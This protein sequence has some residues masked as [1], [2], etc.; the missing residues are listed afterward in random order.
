MH[1]VIHKNITLVARILLGIAYSFD[2]ISNLKVRNVAGGTGTSSRSRS[3]IFANVGAVLSITSGRGHLERPP[4]KSHANDNL[5]CLHTSMSYH[6]HRAF[7]F[8][9]VYVRAQTIT[10]WT[11]VTGKVALISRYSGNK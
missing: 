7:G 3:R 9:H 5:A 6:G 10:C 4:V 8:G 2:D 1:A 11:A